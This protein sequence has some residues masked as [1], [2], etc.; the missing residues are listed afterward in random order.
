MAAVGGL[1]VALPAHATF[2]Q[3]GAVD[4]TNNL[5]WTDNATSASLSAGPAT[6]VEFEFLNPGLT[7]LGDLPATLTISGLTTTP[8]T[9]TGGFIVQPAINGG[10][11]SFI[12]TGTTPLVVKGD[13]FT[14]GANLLSGTFADAAI[15]GATGAQS[16]VFLD[17]SNAMGTVTFTS[18]FLTFDNSNKG[19]SVDLTSIVA[20]LHVG[21]G[22]F[23]DT[24]QTVSAGQFYGGA[25]TGGGGVPEPAA[26]VLMIAGVGFMGA[27]L[28][29]RRTAPDARVV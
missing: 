23:L 4:T 7:F 5:T 25:T 12:Y 17:D 15:G 10:S 2:A 14:T 8:A 21:A 6:A 3:Y 13:T 26:S 1:S 27:S 9:T 24:F 22:G 29:T 16:G 28:R 11:F 19:F 20:P 18:D